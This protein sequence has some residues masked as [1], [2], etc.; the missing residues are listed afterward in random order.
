M[1]FISNMMHEH[2]MSTTDYLKLVLGIVFF[3]LILMSF[4]RKFIQSKFR[5]S[6]MEETNKGT[7]V[8]IE[9]MTC[10]HC[11][12]NVKKTIAGINGVTDVEV[13]LND[14]AA[15]VQGKFNMTELAKAVEE[16]GYKV[17]N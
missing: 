4:Y 1:S 3:V 7:K 9:G 2:N 6:K 10:N 12:M 16:V 15:F 13:S 14:N 11:V 17:V 5:V 8:N